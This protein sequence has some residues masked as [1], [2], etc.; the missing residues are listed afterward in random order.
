MYEMS[1]A[2]ITCGYGGKPERVKRCGTETEVCLRC[3]FSEKCD[4][5]HVKMSGWEL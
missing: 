1:R 3:N 5:P 4:M 2:L